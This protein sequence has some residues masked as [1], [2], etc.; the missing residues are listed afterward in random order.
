MEGV[1]SLEETLDILSTPG[2][3]EAIQEGLREA[4]R[5]QFVDTD[6]LK[7]RCGFRG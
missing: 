5:G 1:E 4:D 6:A 3:Y 2:E 7:K